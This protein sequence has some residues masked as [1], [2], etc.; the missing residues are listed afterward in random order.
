[1]LRRLFGLPERSEMPP[2]VEG[3][4]ISLNRPL[5]RCAIAATYLVI[6]AALSLLVYLMYGKSVLLAV[7][8]TC[9]LLAF[10][11]VGNV[12]VFLRVRPRLVLGL[13][14]IQSASSIRDVDWEIK[15][16]EI[17]EIKLFSK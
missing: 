8:L 9:F 11:L 12:I 4:V 17:A 3:E 16:G 5:R 14:R 13:D 15:Y 7:S 1:M 6:L 2:L 10:P